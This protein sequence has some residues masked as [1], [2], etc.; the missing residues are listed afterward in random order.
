MNWKNYTSMWTGHG[1]MGKILEIIRSELEGS[2]LKDL[3]TLPKFSVRPLDGLSKTTEAVT[4]NGE[5]AI[6][7]FNSQPAPVNNPVDMDVAE[8][9]DS[10]CNTST[11]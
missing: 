9:A 10:A 2:N 5:P 1:I 6:P 4:T 11:S 7:A 8:S 3:P